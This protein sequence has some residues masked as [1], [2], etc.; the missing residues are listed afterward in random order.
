MY[1][2]LGCVNCDGFFLLGWCWWFSVEREVD[3]EGDRQHLA[4]VCIR[5][6]PEVLLE[7]VA[8]GHA[9]PGVVTAASL[10]WSCCLGQAELGA[11]RTNA[12]SAAAGLSYLGP[13]VMPLG[14][15]EAGAAGGEGVC[16]LLP[17]LGS[18]RAWLFTQPFGG[19]STGS[20]PDFVTRPSSVSTRLSV[21]WCHKYF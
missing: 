15:E 4:C 17:S 8:S 21:S 10:R 19:A 12:L 9:G 7:L 1:R 16:P 2:F 3:T 14:D 18:S 5:W 20:L 6:D 11:C 13:L